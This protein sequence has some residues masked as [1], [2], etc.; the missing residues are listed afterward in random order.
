M[1][2]LFGK[3]SLIKISCLCNT[4]A[5][6]TLSSPLGVRNP[7]RGKFQNKEQIL[8]FCERDSASL[9]IVKG[10]FL[11]VHGNG[12]YISINT[13]RGIILI[14]IGFECDC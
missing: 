2:V 14:C 12:F 10:K 3:A 6:R 5:L 13:F 9:G 7:I 1:V 8:S 4:S 11:K